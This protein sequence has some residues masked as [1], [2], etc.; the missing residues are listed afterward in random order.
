MKSKRRK[1]GAHVRIK[2]QKTNYS[3]LAAVAI[4]VVIVIL[5]ALFA[6][7]PGMTGSLMS[8]LIGG[9]KTPQQLNSKNITTN[10]SLT[11][12]DYDVNSSGMILIMQNIGGKP[13]RI[14]N[15]TTDTADGK[16]ITEKFA[17]SNYNLLP[18]E[19]KIYSTNITCAE[20]SYYNFKNIVITLLVMKSPRQSETAYS[21]LDGAI[22][23]I[24]NE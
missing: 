13:I 6:V 18:G 2:N 17:L 5:I 7:F 1:R 21:S 8:S 14:V 23:G 10:F 15:I 24:C 3:L 9:Q 22:T 19:V 20:S 4:I 11:I 16:T 12:K